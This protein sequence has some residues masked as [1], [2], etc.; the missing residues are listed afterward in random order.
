MAKIINKGT[1]A[2]PVGNPVAVFTKKKEDVEKFKDFTL[3]GTGTGTAP[4]QERAASSQAPRI[5]ETSTQPKTQQNQASSQQTTFS[6]ERV[7]ASPL[8][9][10]LAQEKGI[11]LSEIQGSG[12]SGRIL[13]QDVESF[14]P[15]KVE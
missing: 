13:K 6:G 10:T 1:E 11:N 15:K 12:P 8:A 2:L 14:Q 7:F 4:S 9:K 5:E 3:E